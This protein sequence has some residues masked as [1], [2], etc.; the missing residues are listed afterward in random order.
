MGFLVDWIGRKGAIILLT[1]PLFLGWILIAFADNL[2]SLYAGRFLLGFAT[3]G[4]SIGACIFINETSEES[5]R[6][7]LGLSVSLGFRLGGLYSYIVGSFLPYNW[8]ALS[9]C[10]VPILIVGL[11]LFVVETPRYLLSKGQVGKATQAL[12]WLRGIDDVQHE[13]NLVRKFQP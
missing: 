5:I 6:G 13:L 10:F 11:M 2:Y 7:R 3:A 8:L 4:F 12:V 9:L 1:P